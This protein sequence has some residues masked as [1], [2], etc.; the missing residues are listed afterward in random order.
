[1]VRRP[2]RSTR[3]DTLF[4]YTTLFRSSRRRSARGGDPRAVCGY[5]SPVRGR[6]GGGNLRRARRR[7]GRLGGWATRDPRDNIAAD[8]E[9]VAPAA[10]RWR[11]HGELRRREERKSDVEGQGVSVRVDPGVRRS[12]NKKHT[13]YKKREQPIRI[14]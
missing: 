11:A 14:K 4:P 7:R 6:H 10:P 5:R 9:G 13:E 8:D 1:M 12:I 2:P 3:T